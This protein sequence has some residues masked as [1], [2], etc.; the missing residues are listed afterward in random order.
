MEALLHSRLS[1]EGCTCVFGGYYLH[2]AEEEI[3]AR[4]SESLKPQNESVEKPALG[5][6]QPDSRAYTLNSRLHWPLPVG[7]TGCT[8]HCPQPPASAAVPASLR[9][10][11]CPDGCHAVFSRQSS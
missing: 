2:F 6:Q 4:E 10:P 3:K 1:P 5:L 7:G 9:I 11:V 8:A